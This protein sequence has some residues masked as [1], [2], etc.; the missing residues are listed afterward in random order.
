MDSVLPF[1]LALGDDPFI[2]DMF[3][4]GLQLRPSTYPSRHKQ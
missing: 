4:L 1:S 3:D 2:Y